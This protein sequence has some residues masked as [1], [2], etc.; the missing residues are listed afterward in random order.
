[1]KI[2]NENFTPKLCMGI[3]FD[4]GSIPISNFGFG[5]VVDTCLLTGF[6]HAIKSFIDHL[7]SSLEDTDIEKEPK[8]LNN[9]LNTG[10]YLSQFTNKKEN[11]SYCLLF[12]PI[13]NGKFSKY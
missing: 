11:R 8:I 7:A 12:R 13:N 6:T 3:L 4:Q 10:F 5:D 9:F 1:M 2:I